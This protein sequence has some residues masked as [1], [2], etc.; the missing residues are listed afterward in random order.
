MVGYFSWPRSLRL[1]S[2]QALGITLMMRSQFVVGELEPISTMLKEIQPP[3]RSAGRAIHREGFR[4][5]GV[6]VAKIRRDDVAKHTEMKQRL[7][8][9][10][11]NAVVTL[12]NAN[13]PQTKTS[14]FTAKAMPPS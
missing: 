7:D 11:E 9:L 8:Q 3:S 1:S 10:A 13:A 4:H 5:P 14:A 6:Y 12:I 2:L